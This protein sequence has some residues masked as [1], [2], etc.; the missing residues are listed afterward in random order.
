MD[1][2]GT[3]RLLTK[4]AAAKVEHIIYV[5]I[6][7]IGNRVSNMRRKLE[8]ENLISS[9]LIPWSICPSRRVSLVG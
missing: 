7:G 8:A 2:D 6:V 1:R 5:S 3:A 4:A 9:S